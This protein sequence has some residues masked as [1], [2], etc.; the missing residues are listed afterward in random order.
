MRL[1]THWHLLLSIHLVWLA[2]IFTHWRLLLDDLIVL[3]TLDQ[4]D[5]TEVRQEVG[6]HDVELIDVGA[7][8]LRHRYEVISQEQAIICPYAPHLR[9]ALV[10]VVEQ[11]LAMTLQLLRLFGQHESEGLVPVHQELI[12]ATNDIVLRAL[13]TPA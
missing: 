10:A 9:Q 11:L 3:S 4:S 12:L 1:E 5:L 6:P 7:L 2:V 13:E 8:D